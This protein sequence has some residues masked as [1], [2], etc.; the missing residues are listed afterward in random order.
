VSSYR[1]LYHALQAKTQHYPE[2]AQVNHYEPEKLD[3]DVL[4]P[5][6]EMI[7]RFLLRFLLMVFVVTSGYTI[8]VAATG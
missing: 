5:Q 8:Y 1:C 3:F 6:D 7:A 2:A 4:T